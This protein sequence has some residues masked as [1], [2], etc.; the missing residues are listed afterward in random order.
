MGVRRARAQRGTAWTAVE[1]WG[2]AKSQNDQSAISITVD[3]AKG[4]TLGFWPLYLLVTVLLT[5]LGDRR[6][7]GN[8]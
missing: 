5:A 3:S 6:E 7:G 4:K 1:A 2:Q 8:E